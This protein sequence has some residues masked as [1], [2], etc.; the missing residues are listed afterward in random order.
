MRNIDWFSKLS[1]NNIHFKY[2]AVYGIITISVNNDTDTLSFRGEDKTVG[3]NFLYKRE[4]Y[5][6]LVKTDEELL[7]IISE[8]NGITIK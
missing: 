1:E 8:E 3:K 4:Y 6:P 2:N 7:K 5:L